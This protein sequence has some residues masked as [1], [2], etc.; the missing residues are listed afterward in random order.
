[1][2]TIYIDRLFI[3]NFIC[4]YLIL[5]GSARVC[6]V[7]L[8]R[9]RY[10]VAALFGAV[11]AVASV[12]PGFAFLTLLPVKLASGV[13]MALIAFAKES[14]FW[15]CAAVFFAVSAVFG[16]TL[17]AL[18]V[19]GGGMGNAVYLPVSMP[20]L[21]LSFG[22]IYAA[23]SLVFRRTAKSTGK[24]VHTVVI[25]FCG[26]SVTLRA[27]YDSGNCLYDPM[28]G[29]Q[30]LIAEAQQLAP[31]LGE[32]AKDLSPTELITLY[33]GKMRLVPYSAVGTQSGLLPA[34]RPDSLT[35]DGKAR[36][37]ILVA[38]SPTA[39]SGDGFDCII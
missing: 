27:L 3:L 35:V 10:A 19:Q 7:L 6:G 29:S 22:I 13:L 17:W 39:V 25:G 16:G 1:M 18:S 30:V 26:Q 14:K 20:V 5:L 28:T 36:E 32:G 33:A 21:V 24:A 9:V 2:E 31:L 38:I 15:R 37:D 4:D 8:R 12:L 11:Y 23:L 34:F